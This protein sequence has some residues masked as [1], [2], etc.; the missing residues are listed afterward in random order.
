VAEGQVSSVGSHFHD[1]SHSVQTSRGQGMV[2]LLVLKH[3]D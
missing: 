3:L 2:E 1:R